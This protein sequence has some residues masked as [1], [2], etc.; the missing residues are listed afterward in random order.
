MYQSLPGGNTIAGA[1]AV[2]AVVD[3]AEAATVVR[4]AGAAEVAGVSQVAESD[5]S[6]ASAINSASP[7]PKGTVP[8]VV[9]VARPVDAAPRVAGALTVVIGVLWVELPAVAGT[10]V[11]AVVDC[12]APLLGGGIFSP[13]SPQPVRTPQASVAATMLSRPNP[14]PDPFTPRYAR[15]RF[16]HLNVATRGQF[17]YAVYILSPMNTLSIALKEWQLLI[18]ALLTGEQAILLRKGGIL[19]SN[20]EFEL[21]HRRF[22][23]YPTFIHQ[24]PTHTK[25]AWRPRIQTRSAEPEQIMLE[26][27]GEVRHIYEVPSRSAMDKLFDLHLWDTPLI[28]M[29]FSYRPEKPLFLVLVQ[30]FR[31]PRPVTIP[32]T[33]EYA[34]CKSWVP[35]EGAVDLSGA[36]PALTAEALS[37][38]ETR[39]AATFG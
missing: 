19:E 18:G 16:P 32:N 29:R 4:V 25:P 36:T 35:L 13:E 21:E 24:N 34:G 11:G 2:A 12:V 27:Y 6:W 39:I 1:V 9:D 7:G 33:I 31:L 22:L 38:L 5:G 3:G 26:G 8:L 10:D 30:S 15:L 23:F 28:D 37:E 17:L 20:N 14:M